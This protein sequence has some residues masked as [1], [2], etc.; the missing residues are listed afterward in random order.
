MRLVTAELSPELYVASLAGNKQ[1]V[2]A[3]GGASKVLLKP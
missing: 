3:S 1:V 2:H